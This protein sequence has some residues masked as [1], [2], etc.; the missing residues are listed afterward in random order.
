MILN[1]IKV[2]VIIYFIV[3]CLTLNCDY[4]KINAMEELKWI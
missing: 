3:R 2:S 1:V 4:I